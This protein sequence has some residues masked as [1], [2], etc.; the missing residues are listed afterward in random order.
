MRVI[1][2]PCLKDN[3]AYLVVDDAGE[4][5]VVDASEAEP[6][7][8]AAKGRGIVLRAIWSTHHHW[9]HVGGNEA[10]ARELRDAGEG[11]VEVVGHASDRG[12]LPALSR[13]VETGD[14][15]RAGGVEARC[16]HIPGHTLGAVAYFVDTGTERALFTGDTLFVAGCGRL[17]EGTPADMSASL[18]RL[19][20]LPGDTLVYCGHEYT[21]QNLRFAEHAEPNNADVA[22]ARD[23]AVGLRAR[24]EPAVGTTLADERLYNPFLRVHSRE[25]RQ[26]LGIPPGADDVTAFARVRAIKDAF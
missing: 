4:G 8:A 20:G 15:V 2:V 7:R 25:L 22:R 14:V 5:A 24:G 16:I 19:L 9:D 26:T 21:I 18:T 1:P 11:P 17:F 3:Y 10:L 23:R 6:V 13:G 12:R